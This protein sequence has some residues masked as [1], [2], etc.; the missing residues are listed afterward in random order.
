MEPAAP[1]SPVSLKPGDLRPTTVG[2]DLSRS[3]IIDLT[4][5]Q[6]QGHELDQDAIDRVFRPVQA[7]V[8]A[9]IDAA[10]GEAELTGRVELAF[11]IQQSGAVS[12][13]RLEAPSYLVRRGLYG[14]VRPIVAPL[15]FPPSSRSQIV[16]YPFTIR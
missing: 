7:A 2:D 16:R 4:R 9:C 1:P 11:R 3:E 5:Q 8:V 13:V 12:G 14:C 10:R 6:G 15:Q